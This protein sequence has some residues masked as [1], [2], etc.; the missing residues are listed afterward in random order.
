[1]KNDLTTGHV[2]RIALIILAVLLGGVVGFVYGSG[3]GAANYA[4]DNTTANI[5]SVTKSTA[6]PVASVKPTVAATPTP[7]PANPVVTNSFG[8]FTF[9]LPSS[10]YVTYLTTNCEGLCVNNLTIAKKQNATVYKELSITLSVIDYGKAQTVTEWN[11]AV[12]YDEKAAGTVSIGGVTA[13]KY[14]E[15]GLFSSDSYR[16]VRGNFAYYLKV[17]DRAGSDKADQK[18]VADL[19]LSSFKFTN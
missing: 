18:T 1:M 19:I 17:D 3:Q 4:E 2:G 8:H 10:N 5:T 15:L 6:T 7:T 12:S 16:F 11:S 13:N 14:L 9:E